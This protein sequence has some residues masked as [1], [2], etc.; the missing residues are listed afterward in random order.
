M[1]FSTKVLLHC[2]SPLSMPIAMI[3]ESCLRGSNS[4]LQL[5]NLETEVE[6]RRLESPVFA[7]FAAELKGK[8]GQTRQFLQSRSCRALPYLCTRH[9]LLRADAA[10]YSMNKL[11]TLLLLWTVSWYSQSSIIT[12]QTRQ[13]L[14]CRSWTWFSTVRVQ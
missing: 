8:L 5:C 2:D 3:M 7:S 10:V 11:P 9:L 1:S 4:V 6:V 12:G 13:F 14:Q